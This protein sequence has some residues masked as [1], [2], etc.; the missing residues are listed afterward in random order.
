MSQPHV[1][2]TTS[3]ALA[4][5]GCDRATAYHMSNKILR[6]EDGI[7]VWLERYVLSRILPLRRRIDALHP[8][9][10]SL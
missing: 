9:T 3:I 5:D 4:A 6:R 1:S 10:L 8:Q 2:M 7:Y